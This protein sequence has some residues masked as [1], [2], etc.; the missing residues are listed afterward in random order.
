MSDA[1]NDPAIQAVA[2]AV[3]R[4]SASDPQPS[5]SGY[6]LSRSSETQASR[7]ALMTLLSS[8]KRSSKEASASRWLV[9][10]HRRASPG[11]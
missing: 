10:D 6:N 2:S 7:S 3:L 11:A 1:L 5:G 4:S 8:R 9:A